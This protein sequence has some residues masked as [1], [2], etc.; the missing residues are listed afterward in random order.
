MYLCFT[1]CMCVCAL[2][3]VSMSLNIKANNYTKDTKRWRNVRKRLN[4]FRV[5]RLIVQ[6]QQLLCGDMRCLP[7][8][9]ELSIA[10]SRVAPLLILVSVNIIATHPLQAVD[11]IVTRHLLEQNINQ[12]QNVFVANFC[13]FFRNFD[14]ACFG[15]LFDVSEQ[16][17]FWCICCRRKDINRL[18]PPKCSRPR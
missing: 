4:L 16:A 18:F 1:A 9:R 7:S 15:G 2:V 5:H 12:K 17:Q 13:Y 14:D 8:W 3:F 11:N 6:S 10:Q